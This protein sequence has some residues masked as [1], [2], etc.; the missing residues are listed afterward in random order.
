MVNVD[1]F[2]VNFPD[3]FVAVMSGKNPFN[4]KLN[5]IKKPRAKKAAGEI[6]KKIRSERKIAAVTPKEKTPV[7]TGFDSIIKDQKIR[8]NA[9]NK[10]VDLS[11]KG[12]CRAL[13]I[14]G[15][16]GMGK[17]YDT[18][19]QIK[20]A[21]N[22]GKISYKLLKGYARPTGL[23][24]ALYEFRKSGQLLVIDDCDAIFRD[25]VGLNILKAALDSG[26]ER[27]ISWATETKMQLENGG[28]VPT[29]FVYEGSVIFITN[30]CFDDEIGKKGKLAPHFEAL[31]SRCHYIDTNIKTNRERL[32][33]LIHIAYDQGMYDR[34]GIS[35][36]GQTE[37]IQ[38]I[39]KNAD[40]L[41]EISL[42]MAKKI[43]QLYLADSQNWKSMAEVTC[44]KKSK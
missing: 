6:A 41:R 3:G 15:S 44:L 27:H 24:K 16:P 4:P 32:V 7:I 21:V 34:L 17:T 28:K 10:M 14:S 12:D 25:E 33:R 13:I 38:W 35:Q 42:R 18:M 20:E 36:K 37:I 22:K 30:V 19:N 26:D 8:F 31:L 29:S 11:I 1:R 23:Y 40:K 43:G 2:D 5:P 9:I 39:E